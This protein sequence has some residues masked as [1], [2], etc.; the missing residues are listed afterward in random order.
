MAIRSNGYNASEH[1]SK[2]K[3]LGVILGIVMGA[4]A[5][6]G[7]GFAWFGLTFVAALDTAFHAN[8]YFWV[9]LIVVVGLGVWAAVSQSNVTM[10]VVGTV[11]AV[12]MMSM[13]IYAGAFHPYNVNHEYSQLVKTVEKASSFEDRAPYVVAAAYASR[14]Q[15]EV[16]GERDEVHFVP[17]GDSEGT[18]YTSMV[19]AR[20]VPGF[21]G[22]EAV[23]ELDI[24]A[25]GPIPSGSSTSCEVPENM[26]KLMGAGFPWSSL[27]RAIHMV[28]PGAHW[29]K[30]D[31][32]G[33]CDDE[34]APVYVV[35][36]VKYTGF[37]VVLQEANGAMVY[38]PEGLVHMDAKE[39]LE[40]EI[41]GPT[42]PRSLAMKYRE[43][44]TA[45]G[46]ITDSW[47]ARVGYDSTDK[48]MEDANAGNTSEFTL[49]DTDGFIH[50]VTP[51]TPRGSSQSITAT[52]EM[53]AQQG[54]SGPIVNTTV[55]LPA[56]STLQTAIR[57]SSVQ[58]DTEW[59]VRWGSGMRVYEVLPSKDGNWVAS[60]GQGQAV[61]YR[62][63]ISP[64]GVVSVVRTEPKADSEDVG[65]GETVVIDGGKPLA[66]MTDDELLDLVD[67]AIK[68][69]KSR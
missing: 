8:M 44:L 41:Q 26:G 21:R 50:Y 7:L 9:P 5:V 37:W 51:L 33:Y 60:I 23:V 13:F 56:T 4:I 12:G 42:F 16:V 66:E 69:L 38:T 22:Y 32:Y 2:D 14:D 47:S 34:G 31:S 20:G 24:P 68:E 6:L 55:D 61:S 15:G 28:E 3:H 30:A 45:S 48:D 52:F 19:V 54:D 29:D 58:G 35:P 62:A 67:A 10:V 40:N 17:G 57:E 39:L 43:S 18:R 65:T 1:L 53:P 11:A 64:K 36:L 59:A 63:S 25:V 27:N 46:S 49:V